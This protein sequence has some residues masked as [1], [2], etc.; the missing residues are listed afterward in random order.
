MSEVLKNRLG[1]SVTGVEISSD[2]GAL[3]AE[4]CDHLIIGDAEQLDLEQ[5][6]AGNSFDCIILADI[7]EHL[8]RPDVL[9]RRVAPFLASGGAIVA[10]IPNIAHGSVRLAL[11]EGHFRY[12]ET[13]L[14]D[15]THIRFFTRD[16]LQE[17]LEANGYSITHWM[18]KCQDI[19]DTEIPVSRDNVSVDLWNRL[20]ND[21]EAT[22]YQF[23]IR[24]VLT[25][26]STGGSGLC[27][28]ESAAMKPVQ[29][30]TRTLTEHER[31]VIERDKWIALLQHDIAE[32]DELI[33]TLQAQDEQRL[34]WIDQLKDDLTQRF[35]RIVS[36]QAEHEEWRA[37]IKQLQRDIARRDELLAV[38]RGIAT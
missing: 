27:A 3:A 37:W 12:S 30:F 8:L 14:L 1:C 23:V 13:G 22:T 20:A 25:A 29:Q 11:L 28:D 2:A 35:E 15:S 10:S 24:A 17:L 9:L 38:L 31:L 7:L 4:H 18:R 36:L 21:L 34:A 5:I 16:S 19:T 6:L 26:A 33:L 32:R